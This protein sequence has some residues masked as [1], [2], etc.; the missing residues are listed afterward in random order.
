M[1]QITKFVAQLQREL[2][3][4]NSLK[5]NMTSAEEECLP[6][7]NVNVESKRKKEG[8]IDL[9]RAFVVLTK[10]PKSSEK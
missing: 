4:Y 7:F 8:S 1:T 2:A 6:G 5:I 10:L 3:G 9:D